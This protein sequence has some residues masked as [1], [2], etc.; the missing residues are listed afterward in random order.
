MGGKKGEGGGGERG[1][2]Q[3]TVRRRRLT[4][5]R[6]NLKYFQVDIIFYI[7]K[8]WDLLTINIF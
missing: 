4:F 1:G 6:I 8:K 5:S 2:L 7:I 3:C